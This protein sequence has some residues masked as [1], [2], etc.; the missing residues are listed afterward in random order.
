MEGIEMFYCPTI[1]YQHFSELMPL[2]HCD[3]QKCFTFSPIFL[4]QTG[5][6]QGLRVVCFSFTHGKEQSKL[7]LGIT[8]PLSGI[9]EGARVGCFS[10]PS[11]LWLYT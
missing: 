4:V 5:S 6:L 7:E 1:R 3:F 8:F 9:L 11:S 2:G 10:S